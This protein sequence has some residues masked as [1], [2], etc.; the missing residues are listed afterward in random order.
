VKVVLSHPQS[1]FR[2][3][4]PPCSK[5]GW[6]R[7]WLNLASLER[8]RYAFKEKFPN[9]QVTTTY[10]SSAARQLGGRHRHRRG[11]NNFVKPSPAVLSELKKPAVGEPVRSL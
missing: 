9:L 10:G 7:P 8:A 4:Q 3:S 2:L 5:Q 11:R 6:Q 1:R